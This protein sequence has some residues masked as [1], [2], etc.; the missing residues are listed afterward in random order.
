MREARVPEKLTYSTQEKV[1]EN[2]ARPTAI[3]RRSVGV[4]LLALIVLAVVVAIPAALS[5]VP[6]DADT[7]F[8]VNKTGDGQ[9]ANLANA[10]C[11]AN[12]SQSGK[13]CTLRAAIEE[14]N[15]TPGVDTINFNI[16]GTDPVKT[17][18][19]ASLLPTIT[20]SVIIN[21]YS[22][23]GAS[24]NTRATGNNAILNIQ[25]NGT[26]AGVQAK[27]LAIEADD[28]T[29][30]GLVINRFDGRG[31]VVEGFNTTGNKVQGNFIGT[32]AAGTVDLGNSNDGVDVFGS[33]D[34]TV[35]GT[36]RAAR[37]VISGNGDEGVQI[38]GDS[39]TENEVLG[40]YIGTD[41]SGTSDLGNSG[42]GVIIVD[43]RDNAIGGT[44]A[45]A[46]N[47]ISGNNRNGVQIQDGFSPGIPTG[48]EVQG[49]FIGT[50][51]SGAQPLGNSLGGVSVDDASSNTVGGTEPG[52][53][54]IISGNIAEGVLIQ[55]TDAT[56]NKIEG[57]FIGTNVSGTQPLG[58]GSDGVRISRASDNTVGGTASGATNVIS[59]NSGSNA[60][61]VEIFGSEATGNQVLG[62][63][64]GTRADGSGDLGNTDDGVAILAPD[65]TIGGT[66]VAARNLISGNC[67]D[68]VS[69]VGSAANGNEV[70]GNFI[71]VNDNDGVD[72]SGDGNTIGGAT[73]AEGNSIFANGDDGVDVFSS[74]E[75]N[76]V[77]SNRI[78]DNVG[79]GID[80]LGA[81]GV[82]N[83]DTDDPDTG[84]N[85]LQN[86][87]VIA[88]AIRSSSGITTI[89]GTINSNLSQS[90]TIQCFQADGDPTDHGEGQFF[91]GSTTTATNANGDSS[92]FTC[93]SNDPEVGQEVSVTAT[94]TTGTATNTAIGDTSEFSRNAV[95]SGP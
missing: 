76:S 22:Q 8:T 72:L 2:V 27:G 62:N 95:V 55:N 16:G 66:T 32:N 57:N 34:N 40:N 41:K 54:N 37:N 51:V 85:N 90:F 87:P 42:E 68:G 93:T 38:L 36:A 31:I 17:I 14:S 24:A 11:D 69:M 25:L 63:R 46:A 19:P 59:G 13:Q 67:G 91:L 39:A 79:L 10:A 77:L 1:V 56:G 94:N 4:R 70:K 83:N 82:T 26:N 6:A 84:A 9:D 88:S 3:R 75:G 92:V 29:V 47:V 65:N 81:N 52:A 60:D 80:L 12:A 50:N 48:N 5:P 89:T 44:A 64:I 35:G 33:S 28:S 15:D 21:G 7:T 58:N 71:R 53:R 23:P 49:N 61:G 18:S 73:S 20:E 45:G 86:F 43:A 74:G 30:K 78:F